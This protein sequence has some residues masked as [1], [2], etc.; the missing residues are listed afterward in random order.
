MSG[1]DR[2]TTGLNPELDASV[3]VVLEG[4][5]L[6]DNNGTSI[7]ENFIKCSKD[8]SC[9]MAPNDIRIYGGQGEM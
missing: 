4:G 9:A 7:S 3:L 8:P 1:R 5:I 6:I 2:S